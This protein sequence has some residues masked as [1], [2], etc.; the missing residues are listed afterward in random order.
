MFAIPLSV[1][2]QQLYCICWLQSNVLSCRAAH[3][4]GEGTPET[5]AEQQLVVLARKVTRCRQRED[6]GGLRIR[7]N[8]LQVVMA[9]WPDQGGLRIRSNWLLVVMAGWPINPVPV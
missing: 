6:Q 5:R 4:P 9:G 7:S 2:S 1:S 3:M 8:W